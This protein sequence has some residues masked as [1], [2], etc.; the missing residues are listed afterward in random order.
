MCFRH[1]FV[2]WMLIIIIDILLLNVENQFDVWVCSIV[3]P[4]KQ[5]LH[6]INLCSSSACLKCCEMYSHCFLKSFSET[7]QG[8]TYNFT[9]RMLLLICTYCFFEMHGTWQKSLLHFHLV[10]IFFFF[11]WRLTAAALLWLVCRL[12][13]HTTYIEYLCKKVWCILYA[14]KYIFHVLYFSL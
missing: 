14:S 5:V 11:F 6:L 4:W 1:C 13:D 2:S 9:Y 3:S 10:E 7:V 8:T 12:A